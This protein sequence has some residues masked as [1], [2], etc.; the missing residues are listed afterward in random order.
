MFKLQRSERNPIL[1]PR[2]EN[3]WE[4]GAVFNPAAILRDGKVQLLYRAADTD[5]HYVSQLGLATSVDGFS[6]ERVRTSRC[7]GRKPTTNGGRSRTR[8]WSSSRARST[9][10]TWS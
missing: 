2:P 1:A 4:A 5:T 3:E 8:A 10:P 9:S 6:F 7:S